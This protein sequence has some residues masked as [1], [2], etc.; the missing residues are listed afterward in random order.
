MQMIEVIMTICH[1][2]QNLAC[3]VVV[4]N[5]K[6]FFFVFVAYYNATFSDFN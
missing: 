3:F 2:C 6:P 5:K 4:I 1:G